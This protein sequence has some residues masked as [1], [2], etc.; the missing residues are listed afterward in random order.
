MFKALRLSDAGVKAAR[1]HE[2]IIGKKVMARGA[3]SAVFDN[4]KT[5]LKLTL[6]KHAY[7]MA[8]DVVMG[9]KGDHFTRMVYNH[10]EVGEVW[11]EPLY[12][13]E[14]EKLEKLPKTGELRSLARKIAKRTTKHTS[15][16]MMTRSFGGVSTR[17]A[18]C[19]AIEEL[20]QDES[21]PDSLQFA[22]GDLHDFVH[23]IDAG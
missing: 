12:L 20:S 22:F 19:L 6:D 5:V 21:L 3:F 10:G 18:L 16:H 14:C 17:Q 23:R 13:F 7:S 8:C 15:H 1:Q 9:L 4:D 11:G 2:A